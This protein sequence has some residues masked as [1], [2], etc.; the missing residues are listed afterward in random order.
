MRATLPLGLFCL[1]SLLGGCAKDLQVTSI[2]DNRPR[3]GIGYVLPF[4]QYAVKESWTLDYCPDPK[5]PDALHGSAPKISLKV[6]ATAG[7]AD[8]GDLA[9]MVNPQDLQTLTNVTAFSAKWQD[10]RNMLASINGSAEDHTAQIIGNLTKIAVKVLPLAMGAP[11]LAPP[12]G[13]PSHAPAAGVECSDEAVNNLEA[14]KEGKA[15]LDA[16]STLVDDRAAEVE[17]LSAKVQQQ[18]SNV[19][20]G[21]KKALGDAIDLLVSARAQQSDAADRFAAIVKRISFTRSLVWPT[22]G[23][24]FSHGPDRLPDEILAKWIKPQSLDLVRAHPLYLQ[25][26]RTGSFGRQPV[27]PNLTPA[28]M[29]GVDD[30]SPVAVEDGAG[31]SAL[32]DRNIAGLRYRMPAAGRLVACRRSPCGSADP[33]GVIASF[34]GPVAQI[35]FVNV[36]PFR[37]RVFGNNSFSAEFAADGSLKSAGYDQKAA[38]AEVATGAVADSVGQLS[39]VLSPTARLASS[40]SYLKALK[41]QRDALEAIKEQPG[42]AE[43]SEKASLDADTALINAKIANLNATIALQEL[44]AKQVGGN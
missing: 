17:R 27:R 40:T 30:P 24:S 4:T 15:A 33:D 19:D 6:E 44:Q 5:Q 16:A 29:V 39:D 26:E 43:S 12:G 3:V 2:Q 37:S 31:P 32:P 34:D 28:E 11:G 13:R 9:F 41:D 36:L 20:E 38:P 42:T 21:T 35:G 7:S 10:G 18:G 23:N 14:A 25:L 8:D 1:S 22:D